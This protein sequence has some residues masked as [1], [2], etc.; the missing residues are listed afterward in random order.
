MDLSHSLVLEDEMLIF[1]HI[2]IETN[3]LDQTVD[4]YETVLNTKKGERPVFPFPGAWLYSGDRPLIHIMESP[5]KENKNSNTSGLNHVAFDGQDLVGTLQRLEAGNV[6]YR[7]L[8]IPST[9]DVQIFVQDPN[10]IV[11]ELLFQREIRT[12]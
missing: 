3:K 8:K 2:N 7:K 11:I 12:R 4:F 9:E 6:A 5:N 1:N 10:G